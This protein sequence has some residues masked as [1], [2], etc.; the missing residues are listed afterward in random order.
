MSRGRS[1]IPVVIAFGSIAQ[2]ASPTAAAP[3]SLSLAEAVQL[4]IAI[5]PVVAQAH[6]ADDRTALG[7]LRAQL[8]RVSV[9]VD[10]SLQEM[11][12][13]TNLGGPTM[14]NCAVAG[15]TYGTDPATCQSMGGVSSA[16]GDQSPSG[17]LGLLNVQA[18]VNAPLFS[19]FRVSANVKRAEL[20]RDAAIVSI[21]QARK[22]TALAVAR[23]YWGVRRLQLIGDVQVASL[24]RMHEAETNADARAR[25]GLAPPVDVNRARLVRL[26]KEATIADLVGQARETLA[27]F[28]VT[29]RLDGDVT[30]AD[31]PS[32]PD[33]PPPSVDDLVASARTGRPELASAK[34][35]TATQHQLVRMAQSSYF[36]QLSAFGLLQ[37]GNNPFILGTGA[38][39]YST[40]TAN[41]L[42]GVSGN[43]T[44]GASLTMNFFD[45]FN[46]YTATKDAKYEEF[47]L[48]E[49]EKR[50]DRI[51]ESDVRFAHAH[52][53]R[54]YG[55][56]G[57]LLAARDVAL[58]NVQIL[59]GRYRD[60]EAL[61]IEL[62][63]A[64]NALADLEVQLAD[65]TA[66]LQVGWIEL[67]ASLG[68]VVGARQ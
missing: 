51:V 23:A 45:T 11:W 65:L 64:Q 19:G 66:Q 13:K 20:S 22:D 7:V 53:L 47:R 1:I 68:S 30:L 27:Q 62:L 55:R 67:D 38:R 10:G 2:V 8:D 37:F 32:F 50:F 44:L 33:A 24:A 34:L 57:P 4:A 54:L 48:I 3:R 28:D 9:K 41:P 56:R 46:T 6:I 29:L 21:R 12:N 17:S 49:E 35:Q 18:A 14:Y 52:L 59:E 43:L 63:D 42:S 16:A 31:P 25:S 39:S 15:I 61:V 58:D 36:P 60:G 5:D 26:Q 40:S